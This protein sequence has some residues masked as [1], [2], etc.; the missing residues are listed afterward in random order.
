MKMN[1]DVK[2]PCLLLRRVLNTLQFQISNIMIINHIHFSIL[3]IF[4]SWS[5]IGSYALIINSIHVQ[6]VHAFIEFYGVIN[7]TAKVVFLS[8]KKLHHMS[9]HRFFTMDCLET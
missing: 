1:K 8:F 9:Y 3:Q 7:I 2:Y 6:F 4:R 5:F